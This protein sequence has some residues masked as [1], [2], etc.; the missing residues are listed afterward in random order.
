MC[1]CVSSFL[2]FFRFILSKEENKEK[3]YDKEGRAGITHPRGRSRALK[4]TL[5]ARL[6]LCREEWEKGLV[7]V[8]VCVFEDIVQSPFLLFFKEIGTILCE[9]SAQ[10]V[11][12]AFSVLPTCRRH[13]RVSHTHTRATITNEMGEKSHIE[14]INLSRFVL[15]AATIAFRQVCPQLRREK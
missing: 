7:C 15:G 3:S 11:S 13:E 8:C 14:K 9:A 6:C 5:T 1:V 10:L 4:H 12:M 2:S